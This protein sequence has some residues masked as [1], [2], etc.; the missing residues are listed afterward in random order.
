MSN[1]KDSQRH[2]I[3]IPK[4]SHVTNLVIDYCHKKVNHMGRGVTLSNLRQHALL[5][6]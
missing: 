4:K 2:L 6:R 5:G 1:L 3:V